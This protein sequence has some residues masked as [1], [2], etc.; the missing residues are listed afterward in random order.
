MIG[1]ELD[2]LKTFPGG[3]GWLVGSSGN[4]ATLAQLGLELGLSLAK[5]GSH[6]SKL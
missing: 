4:K 6:N 3:G 5:M 1:L 2:K